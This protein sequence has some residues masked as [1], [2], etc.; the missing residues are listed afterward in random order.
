MLNAAR[1]WR[2]S[3]TLLCRGAR[4]AAGARPRGAPRS[5]CRPRAAAA[6][7]D[8]NAAAARGG[9]APEARGGQGSSGG[10]RRRAAPGKP[11]GP[12][13]AAAPS[14][15]A[16]SDHVAAKQAR[17]RAGDDE[18]GK[19]RPHTLRQGASG[20]FWNAAR[21]KLVKSRSN[22]LLVGFRVGQKSG[23]VI[24]APEQWLWRPCCSW[25]GAPG[26]LTIELGPGRTRERLLVAT[27]PQQA[28]QFPCMCAGRPPAHPTLRRPSI[29][30][31][32]SQ[33]QHTPRHRPPNPALTGA[34]CPGRCSH[35][36]HPQPWRRPPVVPSSCRS[37]PGPAPWP[38]ACPPPPPLPPLP[39]RTS[40][41]A[42]RRSSASSSSSRF[43][44]AARV[45]L[46]AGRFRL[47]QL[48]LFAAGAR[49]HKPRLTSLIPTS[50][51][52]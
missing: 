44:A 33:S 43:V 22:C 50:P 46:A 40:R 15:R 3:N 10:R 26:P 31:A 30:W 52:L 20:N 45:L 39:A 25:G 47:L 12:P 14:P 5:P 37:R 17:Y 19:G 38:A 16:G 4:R 28:E 42:W 8:H 7:P 13:P 36:A 27:R 2:H 21:T 35:S 11:Q 29:A 23:S 41:L 9:G 34:P 32:V 6:R 49:G 1:P 18:R 51:A 24:F 48:A